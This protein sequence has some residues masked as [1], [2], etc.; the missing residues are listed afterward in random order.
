MISAK[1]RHLV[2]TWDELFFLYSEEVDY[3][4]RIRKV[5][6]S[7][8]FVPQARVVHI[9]GEYQQNPF[10]SSLLTINRI[11]DYSR[12]HSALSTAIFRLGVIVSETIRAA[13][14]PGHRPALRAALNPALAVQNTTPLGPQRAE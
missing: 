5:G 6:L 14:E 3:L 1:A 13:R 11:R 8:E 4:R 12:H 7:V 9:G 10:L 2:G